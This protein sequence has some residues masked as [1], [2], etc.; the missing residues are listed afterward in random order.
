ME[1]AMEI[2]K[3]RNS[4]PEECYHDARDLMKIYR[5]L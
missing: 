1:L 3:A 2:A 5:K 4:T